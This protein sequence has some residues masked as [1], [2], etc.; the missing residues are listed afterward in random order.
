MVFIFLNPKIKETITFI[1]LLLSVQLV[2]PNTTNPISECYHY[3]TPKYYEIL[4]KNDKVVF[5]HTIK[6]P[7]NIS[8]VSRE[9]IILESINSKD[10]KI[11]AEDESN[12]LFA[13]IDGHFIAEKDVYEIQRQGV[14]KIA[15]NNS[16]TKTAGT[17]FICK[18]GVWY[19]ITPI[20]HNKGLNENE[21][22]NMPENLEFLLAD[23]LREGTLYKNKEAV[24]IFNYE[25]L[26]FK[27]IKN[28]NGSQVK[29]KKINN[30]L[31]KHFLYDDDTF[32]LLDYNEYIDYTDQFTSMTEFTSL[33][34]AEII[35]YNRYNISINTN[36]GIIW[37]YLNFSITD[38]NGNLKK[39]VPIKATYLGTNKEFIHYNGKVYNDFNDLLRNY[40]PLNIDAIIDINALDYDSHFYFDKKS[41]YLF[42]YDT[43]TFNAV[44]WLPSNTTL[45]KNNSLYTYGF[46]G[47]SP[48][49]AD[50]NYIYFIKDPKEKYKTLTHSSEIK[51]LKLAY[52]YDNKLLIENNEIE[53][54]ADRD[55]IEFIGS[56]VNVIQGCDGGRGQHPVIIDV[57]YYFKDRNNVYFYNTSGKKMK[58]L[59]SQH[60][61]DVK[62]DDYDYLSKLT[63]SLIVK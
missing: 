51:D 23:A 50:D 31:K 61:A 22:K 63:S 62:I 34:N 44:S 2:F 40:G 58:K 37:M 52:A 10:F 47:N 7:N 45:Y 32:Y 5:Q 24:Y 26:S 9:T 12:I 19:Y 17:N 35:V 20:S 25:T 16:I 1:I 42:D 11:I 6:D 43:N 21:I 39:I 30:Y 15:N 3:H 36:D 4:V 46:L 33:K 28:L 57:Y 27:K 38:E 56:T 41:K 8:Y 60:I 14:S 59:P 54:I 29:F 13:T 55:T 18:K 53:N 48:F 49:Y